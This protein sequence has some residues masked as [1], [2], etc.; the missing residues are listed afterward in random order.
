VSQDYGKARQ[1]YEKGAA[2]GFAAA[3]NNLGSLY[4]N[5]RGVPQDYVKAR[6][7]WEQAAAQG[8]SEAQ[9]N[10][11][12]LYDDGQGVPQDYVRS[13]MWYNLAAAHLTGDGDKQKNAAKNR[14]EVVGRM[15]PAQVAE[16][17]RLSQ[18]CQAQQFK[19]C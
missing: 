18:Q 1:W 17:Q 11:G 19:G 6:Q 8:S 5:G 4:D 15:I 7:W 9:N 13:Y 16:G 12:V 10:L 14:D 3:Q 2:Q